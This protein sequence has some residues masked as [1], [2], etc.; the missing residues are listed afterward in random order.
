[1]AVCVSQTLGFREQ[2]IPA[3]AIGRSIKTHKRRHSGTQDR[4]RRQAA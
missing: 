2:P 1:L 3:Q 4:N